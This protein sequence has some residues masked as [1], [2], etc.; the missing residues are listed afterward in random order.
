MDDNKAPEEGVKITLSDT[1]KGEV[2]FT[3]AQPF[4]KVVPREVF[5]S[6]R[7]P[8]EVKAIKKPE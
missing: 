6:Y 1:G 2:I 3:R 4:L 5:F 7:P 8:S